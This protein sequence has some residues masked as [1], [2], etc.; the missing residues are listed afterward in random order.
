MRAVTVTSSSPA[1]P[2]EP[3]RAADFFAGIGLAQLG[4]ER[5]GFKVV[6]SNDVSATKHSLHR[7]RFGESG[8]HRYLLRDVRLL[9]ADDY[10]EQI[11]VAWSSFPCTDL[12]VA[13]G[14]A[15]LHRGAA[16]STFWQ[17]IKVLA[18]MKESRPRVVVLENVTAFA[19]SRGGADL[20]SAIRSLNGLGYSVD[21]L[22]IDAAAFVPQSRPRLFVLG[23]RQLMADSS[24]R[25]ELRPSWLDRVFA[26]PTLIT[27]RAQLP[28]L[29]IAADA[30]LKRFLAVETHGS[31]WWSHDQVS[32]YI[33]SLTELQLARL[34]SLRTSPRISVRTAFRRMRNGIARWE[35]RAD[36]LAGCL[37]TSSGGSSKQ[38]LV[39]LGQGRVKIRWML[40]SEY[41]K[42]MGASD[43]DLSETVEHHAY[44]GFG[45]GVCAPVAT[46]L[47]TNYVAPVLGASE[48]RERIARV[49]SCAAST[50]PAAPLP[51]P[52]SYAAM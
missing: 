17:F 4:M 47:M 36:G 1:A 45:D 37:R 35:M 6:W 31:S 30:D 18:Q 29:P 32:R 49:Q 52:V 28:P 39:H 12:S 33:D 14:R 40:P 5:A 34:E 48:Y 43:Y 42:L 44:S 13:G 9:E 21:V 27:H 22:R 25:N 23:V 41:A 26:D 8:D 20:T 7:S 16:S 50:P 38:A 46:W 11:D 10:P 24:V 51:S 15:G 2:S 3:W 19:T